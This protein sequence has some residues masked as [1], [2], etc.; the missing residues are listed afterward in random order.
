MESYLSKFQKLKKLIRLK[1][2]LNLSKPQNA[3]II[4]IKIMEFL[5]FKAKVTFIQLKKEFTKV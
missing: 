1:N 4:N 2:S 5:T 3:N